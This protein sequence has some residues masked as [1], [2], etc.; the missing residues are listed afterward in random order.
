MEDDRLVHVLLTMLHHFY[1]C[2]TGEGAGIRWETRRGLPI[3]CHA[4]DWA[5]KCQ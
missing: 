2:M 3:D 1:I 5:G 4:P